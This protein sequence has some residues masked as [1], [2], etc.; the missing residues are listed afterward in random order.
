MINILKV[1]VISNI[2][3]PDMVL[4][5]I[6]Q[7]LED[8]IDKFDFEERNITLDY[9]KNKISNEELIGFMKNENKK[10][11]NDLNSYSIEVLQPMDLFDSDRESNNLEI[12]LTD[13]RK[14][15]N[16]FK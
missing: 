5:T 6:N 11:N 1:R 3:T 12:A 14:K 9:L 13:L 16:L 10:P 4:A 2:L 7:T 8:L 15:K